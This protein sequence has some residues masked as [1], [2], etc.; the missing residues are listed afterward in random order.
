MHVSKANIFVADLLKIP[1]YALSLV[2]TPIGRPSALLQ[3]TSFYRCKAHVR[4]R[5]NLNLPPTIGYSVLIGC[6]CVFVREP[7]HATRALWVKWTVNKVAGPDHGTQLLYKYN[8]AVTRESSGDDTVVV[9]PCEQETLA[10]ASCLAVLPIGTFS[11]LPGSNTRLSHCYH[12]CFQKKVIISSN[13]EINHKSCPS[14]LIIQKT[15]YS[16]LCT[17]VFLFHHRCC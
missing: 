4:N 15:Y 13:N 7:W 11:L 3:A 17:V 6:A 5:H 1:L 8:N 10:H 12:A 14:I 16:F 9:M 2:V